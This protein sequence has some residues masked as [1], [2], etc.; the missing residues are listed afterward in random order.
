MGEGGSRQAEMIF[1]GHTGCKKNQQSMAGKDPS[2]RRSA[3]NED[4]P[5]D[6]RSSYGIMRHALRHPGE[7]G[8]EQTAISHFTAIVPPV[9]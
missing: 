6:R 8:A 1:R 4:S 7:A 2:K 3:P 9:F 5:L